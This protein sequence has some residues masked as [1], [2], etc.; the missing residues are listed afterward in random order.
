VLL[1]GLLLNVVANAL[2]I[3]RFGI[4]GAAMS[5]S[6]SYTVTALLMV[7]AFHR[8]SRQPL[9]ATLVVRRSDI[10]RLIERMSGRANRRDGRGA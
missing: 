10:R 2:L 3:P 8:L 4:M 6:F 9:R 5:S 7:V 1:I